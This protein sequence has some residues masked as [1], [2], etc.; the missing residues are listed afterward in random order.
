MLEILPHIFGETANFF[1]I[2]CYA[3]SQSMNVCEH[4]RGSSL[5][6]GFIMTTINNHDSLNNKEKY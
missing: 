5:I 3:I 4:E 6:I 1:G 2:Y